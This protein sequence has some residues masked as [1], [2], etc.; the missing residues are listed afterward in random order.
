MYLQEQNA[1]TDGSVESD[2]ETAVNMNKLS[3]VK[4]ADS[5]VHRVSAMRIS[6][7][8]TMDCHQT[9]V[10]VSLLVNNFIGLCLLGWINRRA[11][12]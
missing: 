1:V 9:F 10:K 12:Q 11:A 2:V 8:L 3:P 6:N 5:K 4:P 7:N